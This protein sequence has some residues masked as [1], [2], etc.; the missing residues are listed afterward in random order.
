MGSKGT[1]MSLGVVVMGAG[2]LFQ[3]GPFFSLPSISHQSLYFVG[4]Y[5]FAQRDPDR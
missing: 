1:G 4:T 3:A 2:L 5:F